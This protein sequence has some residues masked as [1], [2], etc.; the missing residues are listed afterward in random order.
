MRKARSES[1]ESSEKK[2]D[3]SNANEEVE[4]GHD[5]GEDIDAEEEDINATS[6]PV[7]GA[8]PDAATKYLPRRKPPA[9]KIAGPAFYHA[10]LRK[11][12]RAARRVA[13]QRRS[14]APARSTSFPT[15]LRDSDS[16]YSRKWQENID[17]F[18][19]AY[20]RA[21]AKQAAAAAAAAA[22]ADST[23]HDS[24]DLPAAAL[25]E[26]EIDKLKAQLGESIA[27]RR[28]ADVAV[29]RARDDLAA[30]L[31][32]NSDLTEEN[33]ALISKVEELER[34]VEAAT[35]LTN[36]LTSKSF[37]S[38]LAKPASFSGNRKSD[39]LQARDWLQ[40]INDYL[41]SSRIAKTVQQQ[42]QFAE[43]YLTGEAR[44][45]WHTIRS[46]LRKPTDADSSAYAGITFEQFQ[47][48]LIDRWDPACSEVNAMHQLE[49]LQQT[50][51]LQAFIS[52]FDR[53]CSF[54]PDMSDREKVHRFLTQIDQGLVPLIAT[55]PATKTRW[56]KY[57]DLRTYALNYVASAPAAARHT[58][59]SKR[60][61]GKIDNVNSTLKRFR[62][63]GAGPSNAGGFHVPRYNRTSDN[64]D[65]A[66]G[67]NSAFREYKNG[68]GAAFSRHHKLVAWCHAN[69]ICLCCYGTYT[70]ATAGQ[71]RQHCKQQPKPRNSFP[72]GYT[73]PK[74]N[75]RT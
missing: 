73:L 70:A 33:L 66:D 71:H 62:H 35:S 9:V 25:A 51:S 56:H 17:K 32:R 44:R 12:A 8:S 29:V 19:A 1:S 60:R 2:T 5:G 59:S 65:S 52:A 46:T 75:K 37:V 11:K 20:A 26:A 47:Q 42:I 27:L 28:V 50:G 72:S 54:V 3:D 24:A 67:N 7:Y 16:S 49:K 14:A 38:S 18:N 43:T 41:S 6:D 10:R 58:F 23:S 15:T 53:L 45:T 36:D 64:S 48:A 39:S 4:D 74:T 30:A 63:D 34:Q 68:N 21:E 13:R 55:D 61:S 40:T 31:Q 57:A 22:A 69:S